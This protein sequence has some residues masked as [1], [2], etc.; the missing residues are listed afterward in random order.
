M[1]TKLTVLGDGAMG[2]TCALLLARRPEHQ[3]ILWSAREE[4]HHIVR[5]KRENVL[6]LPG[7][8]IPESITLTLDFADAV[9]DAALLAMAVPTVYMRNTLQEATRRATVPATVPVVSV[10]KGLEM[11]TFLRPTQIV[12]QILGN[13]PVAV[14]S[15]PGHAEE[16]SRGLPA[17]LVAGSAEAGLAERVQQL[18]T[19]ERFRVYTSADAVG[20]ELAGALK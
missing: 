12:K 3:V 8:P 18:F 7:V 6:F 1:P 5:E 16:I 15:G 4:N 13:R 14:L 19:N 9:R 2:T 11:G 10:A 17:S 20:I